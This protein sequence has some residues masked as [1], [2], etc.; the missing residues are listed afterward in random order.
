MSDRFNTSSAFSLA[1]GSSSAFHPTFPLIGNAVCCPT[2]LHLA[3]YSLPAVARM[4]GRDV[5]VYRNRR[6]SCIL[7]APS[8][9]AGISN[10]IASSTRI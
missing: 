6:V 7:S 8:T 2:S 1:G 10:K 4:T 5:K 9:G 3:T